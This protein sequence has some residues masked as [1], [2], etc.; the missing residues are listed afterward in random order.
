MTMGPSA[1]LMASQRDAPATC[2]FLL[3]CLC[4][5]RCFQQT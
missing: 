3:T 4:T 2:S 5:R 1:A